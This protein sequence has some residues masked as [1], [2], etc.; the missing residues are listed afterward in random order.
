MH[1]HV[2][3]T[4]T[5]MQTYQFPQ[6]GIV[7]TFSPYTTSRMQT[8]FTNSPNIEIVFTFSLSIFFI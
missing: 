3:Y 4:I 8:Y 5:K 1:T 2:W 6:H 7:L